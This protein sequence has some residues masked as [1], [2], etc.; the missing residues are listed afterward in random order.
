[1]KKALIA[2]KIGMTQVFTE[3]GVLIPVTVLEAGPCTVVQKKTMDNDGYEAIQVG[4]EHMKQKIVKKTKN[5]KEINVRKVKMPK[6]GHFAKAGLTEDDLLR[7]LKEFRLDNSSEFEVGQEI[8]ADIFVA[9]D[10]IDV[11]G[12]SKGKGFQGSI[13]RHN[14]SR[15]P[16][17]HGSKSKRVSGSMGA[18]ASPGKVFKGKKLPGHMGAVKITV[19]NLEVIRVDAD[20]N[21]ILV[22]GAVPGARKSIVSIRDAVKA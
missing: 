17:T 10:M 21:L 19:Q 22:K 9:G 15:G 16:M 3:T 7:H 2:K 18:C 6:V 14:Q 8:K 4:F 12:R 20:K 1:M 13:K 11:T 5:G